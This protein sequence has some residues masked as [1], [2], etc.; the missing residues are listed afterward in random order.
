MA[1]DEEV[2]ALQ[3]HLED[4]KANWKAGKT[5]VSELSS[6]EMQK[7][8]G[9]VPPKGQPT[10]Q[11]RERDAKAKHADAK[12]KHAKHAAESPSPS[13]P[14]DPP[15][16][17]PGPASTT[18]PAPTATTE[19]ATATA[20]ATVAAPAASFDLRQVSGGAYI[21]PVKDQGGCGSCV[22]FGSAAAV[23]GTLRWQTRDPNLAVDLSE[24]QLFYCIAVAQQGRNCDIGWNGSAALDAYRDIG[25]ADDACFPYTSGNTACSPCANAQS[26]LTKITGWHYLTTAADMKAWLSTRGP[27]VTRFNVYDDFRYYTGVVDSPTSTTLRGGHCVCAVGYDDI[28]QCWICKNSWG[29]GWGEGG[30]FRIAYGQCGIDYNMLAVEGVTSQIFKSSYVPPGKYLGVGDFVASSNRKYFAIMQGDG[31]FVLYHGSDPSNQGPP[32]WASNT[33]GQGQCFAIMQSDGNFVLY[34]GSDPA[35]QGAFVWNSGRAPGQGQYFAVMQND[36]NFVV[37]QGSDAAHPGAF[38][39]NTG[40]Q[41]GKVTVNN[42]GGYVARCSVEYTI[43]GQRHSESSG[44]FPIAQSYSVEIPCGASN[45]HVKCEDATG[46]IWEPWK[47]ILD[48]TYTNPPTTPPRVT[49]TLTGTTLSPSYSER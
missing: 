45:V 13:D 16:G 29:T 24:A 25:I 31:N 37:Y 40:T 30:F 44:N 17:N 39:W 5:A 27:L 7:R 36:A 22:A 32:F 46:L 43:G 47:T 1:K 14:A 35:H 23:E 19:A 18:D 42:Q 15:P 21:T 33:Y 4:S 48:R 41:N 11:E 26:R 34:K 38:V 6:A 9:W 2:A 10:L 8:L 12:A 20:T 28:N 3:K 49:F